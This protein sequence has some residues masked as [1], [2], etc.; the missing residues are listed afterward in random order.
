MTYYLS[1]VRGEPLPVRGSGQYALPAGTLSSEMRAD[2][3][4]CQAVWKHPVIAVLEALPDAA[5]DEPSQ[6]H[7]HPHGGGEIEGLVCRE[8]YAVRCRTQKSST[9]NQNLDS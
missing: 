4:D 3:Y 2:R 9:A 1:E 5:L 7:R 6:G 8:F